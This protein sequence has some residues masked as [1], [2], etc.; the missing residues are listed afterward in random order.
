MKLLFVK[1]ALDWP[2]VSGH[3]VHAYHMMRACGQLGHELGLVTVTPAVPDALR[4]LPLQ[5][6]QVLTAPGAPPAAANG[7]TFSTLQERYRSYWGIDKGHV[8]RLH[9]I[10]TG[11]RPDATIV[12][13]LDALAYLPAIPP[14]SVRVW[15]AADEWVLHH[16]SL[17]MLG[18]RST[19]SNFRA[20]G[21]KGLYER[22]YA[23]LVDRAW[24][25]S[26]SEKRAMR[27]FAGVGNVDV[28]PN[29]VDAEHYRPLD[30]PEEPRTAVFWG[31]LDFEP[32]VQGLS[33]FCEHVW[34]AVRART[35]DA[36]LTIVGFNPGPAVTALTSIAGIELIPDLPDLRDAV[37]RRAVVVLPFVSGGGIKNKLLEA[38]ALG[39]PIVCTPRATLGL[40]RPDEASLI[41]ATDPARWAEELAALWSDPDRR[42]RHRDA[43][44][45]WVVTR[46]SW[47]T[48]AATAV[49]GIMNSRRRGEA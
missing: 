18:D 29:G 31:R 12:I 46:H 5:V 16:L 7:V 37:S 35:P 21:I 1:H 42:R 6:H 30:V 34:P 41:V 19:W 44:R 47:T 3:D 40:A 8:S 32:N 2:R 39:K 49:D 23:P 27:W 13:G 36:R 22:V 28:V 45:K 11:Y 26:A 43:M 9:T 33:W 15:Y 38:A 14:G 4:G 24:V 20:A 17:V 25:V 48:A 10:V